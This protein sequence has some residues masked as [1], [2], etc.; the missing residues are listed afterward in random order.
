MNTYREAVLINRI[1]QLTVLLFI[2]E[3]RC[4][5]LALLNKE[6]NNT[7]EVAA[8]TLNLLTEKLL[9]VIEAKKTTD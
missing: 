4:Q 6:A 9:E 8:D 1:N 7:V 2:Q 5:Q 3:M